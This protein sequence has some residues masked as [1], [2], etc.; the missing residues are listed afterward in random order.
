MTADCAPSDW[1]DGIQPNG[2]SD[3]TMWEIPRFE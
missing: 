3:S 1:V 2:F